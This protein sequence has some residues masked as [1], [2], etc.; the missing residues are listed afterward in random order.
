MKEMVMEAPSHLFASLTELMEKNPCYNWTANEQIFIV[1]VYNPCQGPS[2]A[3][4]KL[5]RFLDMASAL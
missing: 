1:C 4:W 3:P 5:Q 2:L